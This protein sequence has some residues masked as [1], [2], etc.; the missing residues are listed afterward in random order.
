MK[1]QRTDGEFIE[2]PW[3]TASLPGWVDAAEACDMASD[4]SKQARTTNDS[5]HKA[6]LLRLAGFYWAAGEAEIDVEAIPTDA[7][8]DIIMDDLRDPSLEPPTGVKSAYGNEPN[9]IDA[10]AA[11]E[12][13][14]FVTP[15][16][17]PF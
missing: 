8:W 9:D 7:E 16:D 15:D 10:E 13:Q 5:E 2:V 11:M 6:D 3:R 1:I 4:L 12:S 14:P 17:L